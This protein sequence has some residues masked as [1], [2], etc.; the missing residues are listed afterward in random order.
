VVVSREALLR[1]KRMACRPQD[2]ADREELEA[3]NG[4]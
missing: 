2:V 3:N 1:M 4:D